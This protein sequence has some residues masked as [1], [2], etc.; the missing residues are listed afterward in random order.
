[1]V[2]K[3]ICGHNATVARAAQVDHVANFID[4]ISG[5]APYYC[6][7]Q[8]LIPAGIVPGRSRLHTNKGK[9]DELN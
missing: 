3:I 5:S 8:H 2:G 7:Q 4:T 6:R 1:M 9:P